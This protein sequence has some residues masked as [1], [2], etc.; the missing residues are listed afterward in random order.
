MELMRFRW[1]RCRARRTDFDES[2]GTFMNVRRIIGARLLYLCRRTS[3]VTRIKDQGREHDRRA[4]L[5]CL[6]SVDQGGRTSIITYSSNN[7]R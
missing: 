3:A 2:T 5:C 7:K 6:L 1:R 4:S